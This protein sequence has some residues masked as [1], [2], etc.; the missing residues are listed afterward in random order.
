MMVVIDDDGSESS[1]DEI[2]V[3]MAVLM[4]MIAVLMAMAI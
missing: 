1:V 4:A 2:M 3:V